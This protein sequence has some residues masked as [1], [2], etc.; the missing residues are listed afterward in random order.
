MKVKLL[1]VSKEFCFTLS[2][3]FILIS[4][5]TLRTYLGLEFWKSNHVC[6]L[7][8]EKGSNNHLLINTKYTKIVNLEEG[9][10]PHFETS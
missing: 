7:S 4:F 8:T 6:N 1:F 10:C 9:Q 3:C 5:W 2:V